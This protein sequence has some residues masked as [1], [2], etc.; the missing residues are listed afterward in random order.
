MPIPGLS[1][2]AAARIGRTQS[3]VSLQ[4]AK[5]ENRLQTR[6]LERSIR[7]VSL[8]PSGALLLGDA[9]RILAV[10]DEAATALSAPETAAPFRVGFAEY[11][12]PD[13]LHALL[14]RF[15]CAHPKL[16]FELKLGPGHALREALERGDLDVVI[17]GPDGGDQ[18][19]VLQQEPMVWV[20][21]PERAVE[22]ED[23]LPL[24]AMQPPCS[25]R[26]MAS[27]AL[28]EDGRPWRLATEANSIQGVQSA[29]AAG[30]GIPLWHSRR[31]RDCDRSKTVFRTCPIPR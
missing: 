15:K 21:F 19:L 8:T 4:I 16:T 9:R 10:A 27:D 13:R 11:L 28:A 1:T 30:L 12:A 31:P 5:L 14:G 23:P 26:R 3:A 6:L 22:K 2:A 25:Y 20:G 18:G 29:V 24:I 7:N 17:A